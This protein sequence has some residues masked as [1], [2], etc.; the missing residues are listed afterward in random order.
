MTDA[1]KPDQRRAGGW[2]VV[3]GVLLIA[4]GIL[5]IVIPAP[6][7]LAFALVLAWLLVFAGVVEIAH[8]IHQRAEPGFVW[9]LIVG[10]VTLA[11]GVVM[12]VSPAMAIASLALLFGAFLF[13]SGISTV[14]LALKLRPKAGW[15]WVLFDGVL[16]IGIAVLIALGWPQNSIAFVGILVGICMISGGFWRIV[17]GRAVRAGQVNPA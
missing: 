10:V 12:L 16:S 14:M 8:A 11:L 17:L 4:A 13:A 1:V 2:V 5:A 9:K 3:W 7:A 6:A 15:G